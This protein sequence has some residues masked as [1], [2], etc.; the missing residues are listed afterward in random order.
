MTDLYYDAT[1]RS[2]FLPKALYFAFP[3][4]LYSNTRHQVHGFVLAT[5]FFI[6]YGF[7]IVQGSLLGSG[8]ILT[9]VEWSGSVAVD[10]SIVGIVE[11]VVPAVDGGADGRVQATT[12]T[13]ST[14]AGG[15]SQS[16]QP[17]WTVA[18][19]SSISEKKNQ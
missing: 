9:F 12:P 5:P 7:T 4:L 3:T 15:T 19:P 2:V 6:K 16:P 11:S 13:K 14:A 18:T 17:Y 1:N 10:G 8:S